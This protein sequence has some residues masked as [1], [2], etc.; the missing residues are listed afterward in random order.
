MLIRGASITVVVALA[1]L[2]LRLALQGGV[3]DGV[4]TSCDVRNLF[5]PGVQRVSAKF[6]IR[7]DIPDTDGPELGRVLRGFA[8]AHDWTF[9][10]LSKSRPEVEIIRFN[11]CD[12]THRLMV[13]V[14]KQ[15]WA[16]DL[17][18]SQPSPPRR[19]GF[20]VPLYGDAP[21]SAWQPAAAGIVDALE[22][23]WPGAVRFIDGAG[24]EVDRP[25]FLR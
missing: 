3:S 8:E 5:A 19:Q 25:D 9:R 4:E 23:R 14:N 6:R 17:D 1:V 11:V 13:T 18:P 2:V 21:D 12:S 24:S 16:S 15:R 10:D 22:T 7:I 20:Y